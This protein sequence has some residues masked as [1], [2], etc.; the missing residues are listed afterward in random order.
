MI[1]I[2]FYHEKLKYNLHTIKFAFLR[3][4]SVSFDNEC[5][6]VTTSTIKIGNSP[7]T[8]K[9]SWLLCSQPSQAHP[10]PALPCLHRHCFLSL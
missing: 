4:S 6:Y 1:K 10:L 8:A 2:L 5:S 3:F 7:S 9:A